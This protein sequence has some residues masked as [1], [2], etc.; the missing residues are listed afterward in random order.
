L[1]PYLIA[2]AVLLALAPLGRQF[3][4]K[5]KGGVMFASIPLG[6]ARVGSASENTPSK[7]RRKRA[8][9]EAQW[10]ESRP[11]QTARKRTSATG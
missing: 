6:W 9:P 3:G 10:G 11:R 7:R 4:S 5:T 8:A 2:L 1:T